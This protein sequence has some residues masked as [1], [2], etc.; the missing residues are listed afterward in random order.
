M[1]SLV[2]V[3][4]AVHQLNYDDLFEILRISRENNEMGLVSGLL[5]YMSGNF[6]QVL[7]RPEELVLNI[8]KKIQ[9]DKRHKHI[10]VL[11]QE[12]VE[13]RS[14]TLDRGMC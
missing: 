8:F 6:M 12:P 7:E 14:Q 10:I 5:L 2:Y 9:N 4:T 3:S 13:E 1:I 11:S